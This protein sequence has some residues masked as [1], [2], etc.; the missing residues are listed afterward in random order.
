[1]TDPARDLL[2]RRGYEPAFGARPLKRLI[3]REVQDPLALRLLSGEVSE[4]ETVVVDAAGDELAIRSEPA[5]APVPE[6][7]PAP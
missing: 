5:R 3:Q 6:E 7:T 4:G 2:A 1:V